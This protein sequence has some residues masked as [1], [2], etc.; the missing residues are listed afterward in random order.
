MKEAKLLVIQFRTD[1]SLKHEQ[2]CIYKHTGLQEADIVFF[3]IFDPYQTYD[4]LFEYIKSHPKVP[5]IIGGSGEFYISHPNDDADIQKQVDHM[6]ENMCPIINYVLDN[7]IPVYGSCFGHQ[8]MAYCTGAFV[9]HKEENRETGIYEITLSEAGE[10]DPITSDLPKHFFAVLGHK[11]SVT[12]VP[13]GAALLASSVKCPMQLFKYNDVAYSSQFHPELDRIGLDE[14]LAL[15]PSYVLSEEEQKES[16][17]PRKNV[18]VV[19]KLMK[20][21]LE[22]AGK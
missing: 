6:L 10:I 15:Y 3:N 13:D 9:D 20:N 4:Q 1:A 21:F 18:D 7:K 22:I 16:F 8:L 2:E 19:T 14:R 11:D 12:S 5:I 17:D